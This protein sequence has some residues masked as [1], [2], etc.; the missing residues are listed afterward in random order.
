MLISTLALAHMTDIEKILTEWDRVVKPG[1]NILIT[2]YHPSMFIK[3]ADRS[4]ELEGKTNRIINH[5]HPVNEVKKIF[6]N[7]N[8]SLVD[9]REEMLGELH[10]PYYSAK[11]ALHIYERFKGTPFLYG[12]IL[13]K[14]ASY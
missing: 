14:N 4:F 2:D 1:G 6:F 10:R 11:N 8:Y 3:G 5:I 13:R 7:L 12:M 9:F